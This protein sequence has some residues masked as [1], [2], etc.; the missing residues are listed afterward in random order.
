MAKGDELIV[1]ADVA[2]GAYLTFRPPVNGGAVL[3]NIGC[4]GRIKV[5]RIFGGLSLE[6][7]DHTPGVNS[8]A[9]YNYHV[10]YEHYITIENMEVGNSQIQA[11][12]VITR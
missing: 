10:S 5:Y 9:Y 11:D 2:T 6:I 8:L 12:G 1:H 3:H 4:A 7:M